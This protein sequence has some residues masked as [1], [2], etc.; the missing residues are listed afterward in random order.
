MIFVLTHGDS[1]GKL[2]AKDGEFN[3]EDLYNPF[4]KTSSL[5]GKPKLFFLQACRGSFTDVGVLAKTTETNQ[6]DDFI[7][8]NGSYDGCYAI[9]SYADMLIMYATVEGIVSFRHKLDGSWLIQTLCDEISKNP[10]EDVLSILTGVNNRVAFDKQSC[11]SNNSR[12]DL[13]KQMPVVM[14][15]LTKKFFFTRNAFNG[16]IAAGKI[17]T[18]KKSQSNKGML[19]CLRKCW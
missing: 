2:S 1:K 12:Y 11:F 16:E 8:S 9:P 6:L 18:D 4:I 13:L 7:D 10:H 19:T 5:N 17:I 15:T 3:V 14:H